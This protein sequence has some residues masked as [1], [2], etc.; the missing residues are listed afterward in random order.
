MSEIR[1]EQLDNLGAFDQKNTYYVNK[2]GDDTNSGLNPSSPL[3]TIAK[4]IELILALTGG[5]VPSINNP[6]S[7]H[8]IGGGEYTEIIWTGTNPLPSHVHLYMNEATWGGTLYMSE[9]S[10]AHCRSVNGS[11]GPSTCFVLS[12]GAQPGGATVFVEGDL[13]PGGNGVLGYN[14]TSGVIKLVCGGKIIADSTANDQMF[15]NNQ[16]GEYD[17]VANEIETTVVNPL[18]NMFPSTGTMR[19]N[20][21]ANSIKS[22]SGTI[23]SRIITA[24]G[25]V[26]ANFECNEITSTTGSVYNVS[27][28]PVI[29]IKTNY[30]D[31]AV[32]SVS[33][34][35]N[36]NLNITQDGFDSDRMKIFNDVGGI[37]IKSD[38]AGN[39]TTFEVEG[40]TPMILNPNNIQLGTNSTLA[41]VPQT[42]TNLDTTSIAT[43]TFRK[44]YKYSCTLQV[45][46]GTV[47]Y[48]EFIVTE[49][50]NVPELV[51]N[52][53]NASLCAVTPGA[54]GATQTFNIA[55]DGYGDAAFNLLVTLQGIFRGESSLAATATITGDTKFAVTGIGAEY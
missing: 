46:S 14:A 27:S 37:L 18:F 2:N 44:G 17:I 48:W 50:N 28:G 43:F 16:A 19:V 21:K 26:F 23:T 7:I 36:V 8:V 41:S 31:E 32:A 40:G 3:L 29:N 20:V 39:K 47:C 13:R 5:D 9:F 30:F 54:A 42:F 53:I 25:T 52:T 33:S 15:I 35:A 12:D 11:T 24:S 51:F 4:A 6:Y 38:G 10:T 55:V 1:K 49:N 22:T 34:G 45:Q